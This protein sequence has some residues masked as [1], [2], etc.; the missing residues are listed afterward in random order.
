MLFI[1]KALLKI[2]CFKVDDVDQDTETLLQLRDMEN[3]VNGGSD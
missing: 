2:K 3:I 1:G